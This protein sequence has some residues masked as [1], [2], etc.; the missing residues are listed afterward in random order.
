V[1]DLHFIRLSRQ[2][3][4]EGRPDLA[5]YAQGMR[6]RELLTMRLVDVVITHSAYEAA[7]LEK[8]APAVPVQVVPWAVTPRTVVTPWSNRDGVMFVGN[9]G[10]APNRDAVQWLVQE[11]MP[12]VWEQNPHIP[13]LVAGADLPARLA[14]MVT[15]PRMELLGYVPDVSTVYNR[16]RLAIAPLRFGAGI[17]GKVLEAFSAGLACVM[18]PVAAEGLPLSAPLGHAVATNAASM[19]NLV[20]QLHADAD[21]SA[22]MGQAGLALVRQMFSE[23]ATEAALARALDPL[24]NQS[25]KYSSGENR[26]TVLSDYRSALGTHA[27]QE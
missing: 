7:V 18:T 13:C 17:K 4:I 2:A 6:E 14:A 24:V 1:A 22:S 20:C 19:A 12:L 8:L 9:F 15:V 27:G 21:R 5:R 11:V 23:R 25:S 10:H 16:A 26:V 3:A